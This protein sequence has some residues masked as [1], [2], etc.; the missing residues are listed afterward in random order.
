M[1]RKSYPIDIKKPVFPFGQEYWPNRAEPDSADI[2]FGRATEVR[3]VDIRNALPTPFGFTSFFGEAPLELPNLPKGTERL[4]TYQD[5]SGNNVLI[6]LGMYGA[7]FSTTGTSWDAS[8]APGV[9]ALYAGGDYQYTD[10]SKSSIV[11]SIILNATIDNPSILPGFTYAAGNGTAPFTQDIIMIPIKGTGSVR[12]YYAPE[13]TQMPL[14]VP[15]VYDSLVAYINP[16]VGTPVVGDTYV[17]S[18]IADWSYHTAVAGDTETDIVDA[19]VAGI[20]TRFTSRGITITKDNNNQLKLVSGANWSATKLENPTAYKIPSVLP[21]LGTLLGTLSATRLPLD[22]PISANGNLL[23]CVFHSTN[24][25]TSGSFR[26]YGSSDYPLGGSYSPVIYTTVNSISADGRLSFAAL[27]QLVTS[28]EAYLIP[29]PEYLVAFDRVS[30]TVPVDLT[31][32]IYDSGIPITGQLLGS[33]NP[34]ASRT[35]YPN[36]V[37]ADVVV[38]RI[39]TLQSKGQYGAYTAIAGD[40]IASIVVGVIAAYNVAGLSVAIRNEGT[41]IIYNGNEPLYFQAAPLAT[42]T[43][44]SISSEIVHVKN[45]I[46]VGHNFVNANEY[47]LLYSLVIINRVSSVNVKYVILCDGVP[48]PVTT[49]TGNWTDTNYQFTSAQAIAAAASP[50]TNKLFVRLTG[51]H[52]TVHAT[53]IPGGIIGHIDFKFRL[54]TSGGMLMSPHLGSAGTKLLLAASPIGYDF[55]RVYARAKLPTGDVLR[56][57]GEIVRSESRLGIPIYSQMSSFTSSIDLTLMLPEALVF[58]SF[59]ILTS[60]NNQGNTIGTLT[61]KIGH[62]LPPLLSLTASHP[63]TGVID[64]LLTG[65]PISMAG[66]SIATHMNLTAAELQGLGHVNS[67]SVALVKNSLYCFRQGL[68]YVLQLLQDGSAWQQLVPTF[69]N[70]PQMQGICAA[71]GRLMAWDSANAVYTSAITNRIDFTPSLKTRANVTKV[72]ALIGDIVTALPYKEGYI[73]YAT[74]SIIL[75]VY[76]GGTVSYKYTLLSDREGILNPLDAVSGGET[77]HYAITGNRLVAVSTQGVIGISPEVDN[78]IKSSNLTPRIDFLENRYVTVSL[79]PQLPGYIEHHIE[80][81]T[82]S[83]IPGMPALPGTPDTIIPTV[84]IAAIHVPAV[85]SAPVVMPPIVVP[86]QTITKPDLVVAPVVVPS[87]GVAGSI[88]DPIIVAPVVVPPVIAPEVV[89]PEIVIPDVVVHDHLLNV[90]AIVVPPKVIPGVPAVPGDAIPP[91][92]VPDVIIPGYTIPGYTIPGIPVWDEVLKL[93]AQTASHTPSPV[94]WDISYQKVIGVELFHSDVTYT[95][96]DISTQTFNSH[97]N[98]LASGSIFDASSLASF[99]ATWISDSPLVWGSVGQLITTYILGPLGQAER[100]GTNTAYF[101]HITQSNN[102]L[103]LSNVPTTSASIRVGD[104]PEFMDNANT[105]IM[106][107]V[108]KVALINFVL[109]YHLT[110][111]PRVESADATSTWER[112][113]IPQVTMIIKAYLVFDKYDMPG[114]G[115]N[116]GVLPA[117]E[118]YKFVDTIVTG[119]GPPNVKPLPP[120]T[121]HHKR[122]PGYT[123]PGIV[124]PATTVKGYTIPGYTLPADAATPGG[125]IPGYTIPGYTILVDSKSGNYTRIVDHITK[126]YTIPS[127]IKP[128]HIIEPGYTIPGYTIPGVTIPGQTIPGYTIPGYTVIRSYTIPGYTIPGYIIP[129]YYSPAYDIPGLHI[130]SITIPGIPDTPAV[131]D[132]VIPGGSFIASSGSR[133]AVSPVYTRTLLLDL[134]LKNWGSYDAPHSILTSLSPI[135]ARAVSPITGNTVTQFTYQNLG[136]SLAMLNTLG[137]SS[138]ATEVQLDSY[139][140]FGD[141]GVSVTGKTRFIDCIADYVKETRSGL[142]VWGSQD[143]KSLSPLFRAVA[144]SINT[145]AMVNKILTAKWFRIRVYGR[146]YLKHLTIS[147]EKGGNR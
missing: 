122:V 81:Y 7:L 30:G 28:G 132:V 58:T 60:L 100:A 99:Y 129:G 97:S 66:S 116:G 118:P 95:I 20:T 115:S 123:I 26:F 120:I 40:T 67:W 90:N 63:G 83:I 104:S 77:E 19:L 47:N 9:A 55:V 54:P 35:C 87:S 80:G 45:S 51:K 74:G 102:L 22:L 143:G 8:E 6:A 141:Y 134:D 43:E 21:V 110:Y 106:D 138:L 109:H 94:T 119:M 144:G 79:S 140:E 130:P 105:I 69:I 142:E 64:T 84:D 49:V 73:I 75:A 33:R 147:G 82:G 32:D 37:P 72:D 3:A 36:L 13:V 136:K 42:M 27:N 57:I 1:T 85:N 135:N 78:Y 89:M 76:V 52:L 68:G 137:Q 96:H 34:I 113:V 12:T 128:A 111:V 38:G 131:P 86:P 124:V 71:R 108:I 65:V 11:N 112:G 46:K 139:I 50:A 44:T 2:K 101:Y 53:T 14:D 133:Q 121:V 59:P 18:H 29:A 146:F 91:I 61:D 126:G 39:Y 31:V 41:L 17:L 48:V 25:L 24:P 114:L 117:G 127:Y 23:Q 56:Y 107:E 62:E 5:S 98:V 92:V 70:L 10:T 88:I 4:F 125:V 103:Q 15:S 93:Q 16:A 145:R